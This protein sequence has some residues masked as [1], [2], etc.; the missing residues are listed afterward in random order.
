MF[1]A[2]LRFLSGSESEQEAENA[3]Q[4]Q[5]EHL[6][7]LEKIAVKK[8]ELLKMAHMTK[9]KCNEEHQKRKMEISK[10]Y[11]QKSEEVIAKSDRIRENTQEVEKEIVKLKE[12]LMEVGANYAKTEIEVSREAFKELADQKDEDERRNEMYFNKVSEN[13]AVVHLEEIRTSNIVRAQKNANAKALI[14]Q[15]TTDL[16]QQAGLGKCNLNIQD[17]SYERQNRRHINLKIMEIKKETTDLDHWYQ[18][19]LEVIIAP[20]ELYE[21]LTKCKRKKA[22]DSLTRFSEVLDSMSSK[23][24]DLEHNVGTLE[25]E[26][27]D[28]NRVIQST[29][30]LISSFGP[31]IA[32][33]KLTIEIDE[34]ID[35]IKRDN[36]G[37]L[38]IRLLEAINNIKPIIEGTSDITKQIIGRQWA[39]FDKTD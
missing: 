33:I 2:V 22:R 5:L 11:E 24:N 15:M 26:N 9:L 3:R 8:E 6:R 12:R 10:W 16:Q 19:T 28:L 30:A 31:V 4:K 18:E 35:P 34:I 20:P 17:A 37:V 21:K 13:H 36:F 27:V 23:F 38:K 25:L 1:S 7:K 32:N 29:R 14:Q 39:S